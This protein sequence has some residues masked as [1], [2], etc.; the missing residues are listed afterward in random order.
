MRKTCVLLLFITWSLAAAADVRLGAETPLAPGSIDAVPAA[1]VQGAAQIASNGRGFLAVWQDGREGH[2]GPIYAARLDEAGRPISP[3]GRRIGFGSW[4]L[5]TAEASGGTGYAVAWINNGLRLTRVDEDGMPIE[6]IPIGA[7]NDV[8]AMV[9]F[10]GYPSSLLSLSSNG[11]TYAVRAMSYCYAFY[12]EMIIVTASQRPQYRNDGSR[13]WS[14]KPAGAGYRLVRS[15]FDA[16]THDLFWTIVDDNGAELSS[17]GIFRFPPMTATAVGASDDRVLAAWSGFGED[18]GRLFYT[19]MDR[20]GQVIAATASIPAGAGSEPVGA[21]WDGAEFLLVT[22]ASSTLS[23][24]RI[25]ANGSLLNAQPYVLSTTAMEDPRFAANSSTGVLVWRDRRFSPY[26]D[27][28]SR[29]GVDGPMNLV[30]LS[31]RAQVGVLV[32]IAGSH[33]MVV[34]SDGAP[35]EIRGSIDGLERS[36]ASVP[37][38]VVSSPAVMAGNGSFLVAWKERNG[39]AAT[40]RLVARRYTLDGSPVDAQPIVLLGDV[41]VP[42]DTYDASD[43]PGIAFDGSS[44]LVVTGEYPNGIRMARVDTASG[45]VQTATYAMP[46]Q[47]TGIVSARAVTGA[48][49]WLVP[50]T[51]RNGGNVPSVAAISVSASLGSIHSIPLDAPQYTSEF[52]AVAADP[53]NIG[54]LFAGEGLSFLQT[55]RGGLSPRR[56]RLNSESSARFAL[57]WNGS[58]YVLAWTERTYASDANDVRLRAMRVSPAGQPL[59]AEP[60]DVATGASGTF[61]PSIAVTESGVLIAYSKADTTYGGAPRAYAR[62]LDRLL[63]LPVPPRRQSAR[64]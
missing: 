42:S 36:I 29:A 39:D 56:G 28:V 30:S 13:V 31:G 45:S 18:A 52:F 40:A 9:C 37:G 60:F 63:P 1:L 3:F 7:S 4:P 25:A 38:G 22:R 34:W 14:M 11:S 17:R 61:E 47:V 53:Q 57:A 10:F 12:E 2:F 62:T 44:F 59:D 54:Y 16:G 46:G 27:V 55:T 20:D 32:G 24:F 5:V 8:S 19:V 26:G 41:A 21:Y 23:A 43:R 33:R 48:D 49:H 15:S 6:A 35:Q 58:E 50:F 64:H 51:W